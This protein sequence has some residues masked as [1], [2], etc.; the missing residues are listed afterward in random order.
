MKRTTLVFGACFLTAV[1]GCGIFGILNFAGRDLSDV[2]AA[3]DGPV[4]D[5]SGTFEWLAEISGANTYTITG[6]IAF[7]QEGTR[8]SVG[9]NTHSNPSNRELVGEADLTGNV[10]EIVMVPKNGDTDYTAN[11]TLRFEADGSRF[12]GEFTDT[13]NDFGPAYG[14]RQ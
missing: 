9:P 3:P 7:E 4:P 12:A 8:V 10:L 5:V 14:F 11:V 6:L 2:A 13:N 1:V